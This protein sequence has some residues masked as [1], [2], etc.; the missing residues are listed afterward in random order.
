MIIVKPILPKAM[1]GQSLDIDFSSM[2]SSDLL[3]GTGSQA[4][5]SVIPR[6]PLVA[7]SRQ[8]LLS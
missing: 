6:Y 4:T 3:Y 8:L 1:A 2:S 5:V 7:K